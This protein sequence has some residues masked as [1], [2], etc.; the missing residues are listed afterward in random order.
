ME[1]RRRRDWPTIATQV[2]LALLIL[3][4]LWHLET[5]VVDSTAT[6]TATAIIVQ[7]FLG[8]VETHIC[9]IDDKLK[10][11]SEAACHADFHPPKVSP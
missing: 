2:S 5:R 3:G 11:T 1:N 4:A 8:R 7:D 6:V 10:I 9:D